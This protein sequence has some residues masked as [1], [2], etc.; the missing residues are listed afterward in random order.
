M[1]LELKGKNVL[2]AAGSRGIG[3]AVAE[4][5]LQ[6]GATVTICARDAAMLERARTEMGKWG[7]VRTVS[8][9]VT[10]AA[11]VETAVR[12]A[13]VNGRLDALFVNAGGPPAGKFEDFDDSAWQQAFELNLLS[14]VRLVR[15]ALP[16]MKATGGGAIVQLMSFVVKEPGLWVGN[17]ILSNAIRAG[18]VGLA[19]TLA[20]EFAPFA[21]RVNTVLPGRID[22]E[23]SRGLDASRAQR[24]GRSREEL[25][26]EQARQV[27]LGRYGRPEEVA[28]MIVFLASPRASY[29]TGAT[30]QVDGG[31]V[32]SL[33]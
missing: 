10:R 9:D 19:K 14:S 30:V 20:R 15:A 24:E 1:D 31:L 23:R 18:A 4:G 6:E 8:A 12:Q 25:H 3:R 21:I 29:I 13:A 2:V 33:L 27:P 7:A 26:A 22:T 5:F 16:F 17:L 28:A 11:D 32:A